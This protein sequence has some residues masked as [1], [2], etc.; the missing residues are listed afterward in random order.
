M[1]YTVCNVHCTIYPWHCI[2]LGI[3]SNAYNEQVGL[4]AQIS[5]LL[6]M[7]YHLT[8][9]T[10]LNDKDSSAWTLL[11]IW[12]Y[13]LKEMTWYQVSH[14]FLSFQAI[15]FFLQIPPSYFPSPIANIVVPAQVDGGA[16]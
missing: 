16:A 13:E 4:K 10:E 12:H 8:R 9:A 7:K 14:Y 1:Q 6:T 3:L 5:N 11:G 15:H 2:F